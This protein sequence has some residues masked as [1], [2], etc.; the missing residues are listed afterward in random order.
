MGKQPGWLRAA[1]GTSSM[2]Q[3]ENLR[4]SE[5]LSQTSKGGLLGALLSRAGVVAPVPAE[6]VSKPSQTVRRARKGGA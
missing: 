6:Q 3:R 2:S 4:V 1:V 5:R